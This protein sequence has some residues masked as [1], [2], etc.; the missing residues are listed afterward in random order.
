MPEVCRDHRR[1]TRPPGAPVAAT[2]TCSRRFPR[3]SPR[4]A[5]ALRTSRWCGASA[6]TATAPTSRAQGFHALHGRA[7]PAGDRH[8]AL[9]PRPQG[10]RGDGRRRRLRHR[11]Q[12]LH[13]LVRRNIDMVAIVHNNQ[14]YGLTTGQASPTTDQVMKTPSTP[15]GVLE[16]PVNPVGL[17]IAAGRDVRGARVRRRRRAPDRRS[18]GRRSR[19][20]ASRSWTSSS[21]A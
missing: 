15:G 19:T 2:S 13:P 20:R 7:L 4:A 8:R 12:P 3:C 10:D 21:R 6:A 5:C 14:I 17:A 18:I 1:A 9:Q 16:E 11:R